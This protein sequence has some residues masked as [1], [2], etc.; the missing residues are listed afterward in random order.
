[1]HPEDAKL[2]TV[3]YMRARTCRINNVYQIGNTMHDRLRDRSS[4]YVT[5]AENTMDKRLAGSIRLKL[6]RQHGPWP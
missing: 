4:H 2:R 6:F 1:M 3:F 5:S